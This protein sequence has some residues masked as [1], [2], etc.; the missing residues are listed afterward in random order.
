MGEIKI[1]ID[2]DTLHTKVEGEGYE[3]LNCMYDINDLQTLLGMTTMEE[4]IK[5]DM[6]KVLRVTQ[7]RRS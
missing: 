5:Q 2:L 6:R 7:A 3:G 4:S 1:T